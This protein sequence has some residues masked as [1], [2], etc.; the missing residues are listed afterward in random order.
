VKLLEN[1]RLEEVAR[2][3][4]VVLYEVTREEGDVEAD[5]AE[6]DG[7]VGGCDESVRL[8]LMLTPE[9]IVDN[10]CWRYE[11]WRSVVPER[12]GDLPRTERSQMGE[13]VLLGPKFASI[14]GPIDLETS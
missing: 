14:L 8:I 4:L 10:K 3:Y 9:G 1:V 7:V 12:D 2:L 5:A 6:R 13:G 11:N